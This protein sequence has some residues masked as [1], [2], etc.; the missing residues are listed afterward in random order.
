M[1]SLEEIESSTPSEASWNNF[2][3]DIVEAAKKTYPKERTKEE[4]HQPLDDSRNQRSHARKIQ[5]G[6]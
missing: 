6:P 5:S 3:T 4:T 1:E 2:K